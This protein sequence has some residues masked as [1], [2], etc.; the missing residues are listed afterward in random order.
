[1]CLTRVWLGVFSF[2]DTKMRTT[3]T[4]K[5]NEGVTENRIL[6]NQIPKMI[7]GIMHIIQK[8]QSAIS[9]F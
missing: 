5:N 9:E 8:Y 4:N 6:E 1:M 2:P 7:I 3:P